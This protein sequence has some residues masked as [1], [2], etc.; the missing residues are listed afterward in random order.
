MRRRADSAR[1]RS[2]KSF[3]TDKPLVLA[4]IAPDDYVASVLPETH[5]LWG[6]RRDFERYAADFRVTA[7]TASPRRPFTV[8][9][10]TGERILA[11]CKRYERELRW[12]NKT[13]R[14]SGL[15]AVFTSPEL[16]GRGYASAMLGALLDEE[17][18]VG[19][20]LAFL[21]S[22]IHPAFYERLGFIRVPSRLITLRAGSLDG[23]HSGAIPL[24]EHDWAGVRRCFDALDLQRP[25][26]LKRTPLV[27]VRMRSVWKAPPPP[28]TQ[29]V[30]LVVKNGR[31]VI[32]YVLAR[33]VLADDALVVDDF[34]F[35]DEGRMR[36]P[37]LLRAAAGDL[38]RIAGWLP[39]PVARDALP[40]GAVRPRRSAIAMVL[41]LSSA[42]GAWWQA[43]GEAVRGARADPFWSADH[44]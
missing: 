37:S 13:L 35:N 42:G 17:R 15:G 39:P 3:A 30:H 28:H 21:F 8:G 44:V 43:F 6:A 7:A 2:W 34:G 36:I 16:R 38:A 12:E 20:D 31:R 32:A 11:S 24:E 41:P 25:W 14:A 1:P 33:R 10:R 29:P 26:S 18:S 22:D 23:S 40:R 9:L 19:R 5:A 4:P 27:W